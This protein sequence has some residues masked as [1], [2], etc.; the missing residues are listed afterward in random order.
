MKQESLREIDELVNNQPILKDCKD[1]IFAALELLINVF[2]NGNKLLV[3][4]NGGSAAD[5]DHI[6]G[7][8]MK[9]FEKKR[10]VS[11]EILERISKIN[12]EDAEILKSCQQGL[13]TISLSAH[14]GL[15]TAFNNDCDARAVYA[16]E[17]LGYGKE[18]D[19]IICISTSGNSK[20]VVL[21]SEMA[22]AIG[23]K[24]ISLTGAKESQLSKISD[25]TIRV[26]LTRTYRIQE[27]HLPIY[28]ALC[29]GLENE[30][31]EE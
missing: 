21:A 29:L 18:G 28:H 1:D 27:Y 4:G 14:A 7:E 3:C 2:K 19:A 13:P 16:N 22:K 17:V 8:L 24:V 5:S 9:G 25:V 23:L 15:M 11:K 30:F 12:P 20:N 10:T 26:P 6:V 31:F